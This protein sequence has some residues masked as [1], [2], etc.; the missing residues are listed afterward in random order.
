MSLEQTQGRSF[1]E[2]SDLFSLGTMPYPMLTG[3]MPFEGAN[4]LAAIVPT[5]N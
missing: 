3:K 2:G 4:A 1:D 5:T